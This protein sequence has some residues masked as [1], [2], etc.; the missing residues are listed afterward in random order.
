MTNNTTASKLLLSL[1]AF[2]ILSSPSLYVAAADDLLAQFY[3]S[4][5]PCNICG[6]GVVGSDDTVLE[7]GTGGILTQ[8]YTCGEL[9]KVATE[10][11]FSPAS[12]LL[13]PFAV[14]DRCECIS[15]LPRPVF[16][17]LPT[18]P[19]PPASAPTTTSTTPFESTVF[20]TLEGIDGTEIDAEN[21]EI[22]ES[23][24]AEFLES[25]IDAVEN[26]MCTVENQVLIVDGGSDGGSTVELEVAIT[27]EGTDASLDYGS[28]L[29]ETLT[30][31]LDRLVEELQQA[32]DAFAGVMGVGVSSTTQDGV[33]E[34]EGDD[35]DD[36]DGI[37]FGLDRNTLIAIAAGAFLLMSIACI[38]C[39]GRAPL[40][41]AATR[42][43]KRER[44]EGRPEQPRSATRINQ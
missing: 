36:D 9:Q 18:T 17:P 28:I 12:C 41:S 7:S 3:S 6:D 8:D 23:V 43:R 30:N 16:P 44:E 13:L 27:G 24:C 40:L 1:F 11:Q 15:S 26:V 39:R 42:R 37:I 14:F 33:E 20:I 31:G 35:D 4:Y 5:D 22:F 38:A 34:G 10:G 29:L 19:D 25:E 21:L 32:T 2:I